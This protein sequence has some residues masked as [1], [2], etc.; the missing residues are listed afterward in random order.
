MPPPLLYDLTELQVARQ[1]PLFWLQRAQRTLDS[2]SFYEKH[3]LISYPRTDS[4]HL[5]QNVAATLGRGLRDR[6]PLS[7]LDRA[8]HRRSPLGASDDTK[9]TDHHAI[10][11]N[12]HLLGAAA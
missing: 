3:K 11:P 6:G 1:P 4:R 7:R 5:S 2:H 8:R 10:L 9:V 12:T